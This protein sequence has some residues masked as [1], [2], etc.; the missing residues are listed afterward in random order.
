MQGSGPFRSWESIYLDP[1][2]TY[3]FNGVPINS[4]LGFII[5]TYKKVGFGSL[6]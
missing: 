1:T 2:K 3:L 5:R 6:R 4:R